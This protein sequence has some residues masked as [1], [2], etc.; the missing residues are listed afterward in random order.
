M[1]ATS[2]SSPTSAINPLAADMRR[3]LFLSQA[4]APALATIHDH[5]LCL[6]LAVRDRLLASWVDTAETYT[7]QTVRTAVYLSA[8]YLLGPHLENNLVNLGLHKEAEAACS[9]LG[10]S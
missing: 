7:N 10:L 6:A 5:Y 9:E 4:K 1:V 2:L 3:H 8:E